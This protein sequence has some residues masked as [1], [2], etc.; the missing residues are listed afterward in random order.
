MTVLVAKINLPSTSDTV[1]EPSAVP[2]SAED[3]I[4]IS[5][6]EPDG[7]FTIFVLNVPVLKQLEKPF[8]K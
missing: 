5:E 8:N 2:D 4:I 7:S 1:V 6:G 3:P